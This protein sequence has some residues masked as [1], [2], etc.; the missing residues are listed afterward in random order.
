MS[1]EFLVTKEPLSITLFRKVVSFQESFWGRKLGIDWNGIYRS[2]YLPFFLDIFYKPITYDIEI[3]S[4]YI[5]INS[6]MKQ[7]RC[8]LCIEEPLS[9]VHLKKGITSDQNT[10]SN[11]HLLIIM[12]QNSFP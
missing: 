1:T 3:N 6:M 10:I 5:L 8:F 12:G 7:L 9:L 2:L 11:F 4:S